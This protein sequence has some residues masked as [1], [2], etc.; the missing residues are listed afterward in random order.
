MT[1]MTMMNSFPQYSVVPGTYGK[2]YYCYLV[3]VIVDEGVD[4]VSTGIT[5]ITYTFVPVQDIALYSCGFTHNE[6]DCP[7]NKKNIFVK[8][9]LKKKSKQ[10]LGI[11][12]QIYIYIS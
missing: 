9:N 11:L 2:Q 12:K 10:K 5:F 4:Q 1:M 6:N 3:R 7:Q 8:I